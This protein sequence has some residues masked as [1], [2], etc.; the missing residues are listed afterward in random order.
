MTDLVEDNVL[1]EIIIFIGAIVGI[2][3]VIALLYKFL[4]PMTQK[5]KAIPGKSKSLSHENVIKLAE[6]YYEIGQLTKAITLLEEYIKSNPHDLIVREM[7]GNYYIEKNQL[8]KAEKQF[9]HI[10]SI[11]SGNKKALE[12]LGDCYYYQNKHN[13]AVE[14]YARIL[15]QAP[16][17]H[18]ARYKLADALSKLDQ[19]E[20]AIKELRK[21]IAKDH[22]NLD[23]RKKLAELLTNKGEFKRAVAELEEVIKLETNN[24]DIINKC[25]NL[26]LKIG[27]LAN[28]AITFKKAIDIDDSDVN[29]HIRLAN[30]YIK[31]QNYDKA[32]KIYN[33][34]IEKGHEVTPDMQYELANI[35]FGSENYEKA[36]S[37]CKQLIK[38]NQMVEKASFL[39]AASCRKLD[40]FEDA[41]NAFKDLI[42]ETSSSEREAKYKNEIAEVLCDWGNQN[43]AKA[44]YTAA[45]DK[46][47]EAVHYNPK[48]PKYY[49][50]LGKTNQ[51]TKNYDS[52]ISHFNKTLEFS[53]ADIE[54]L[55]NI[56]QAYEEMEDNNTAIQLYYE[57]VKRYPDHYQARHS[58]GI[59]LG[60]AGFHEQARTELAKAIE[61]EPE[62]PDAYF[63][64]GLVYELLN[65]F[66]KAKEQ[67][68]KA[69]DLDPNHV[70]ARNNLEILMER[71]QNIN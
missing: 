41:F 59:A 6:E 48:N 2:G 15:N 9:S 36:I 10:L 5:N 32:S 67:Y 23:A 57:A 27:D 54:T 33:D 45:L 44:D 20:Q 8:Q 31:L 22:Y 47:V 21:I 69:L 26:Y 71:H 18:E 19:V 13:K 64:Y 43:F 58:L 1:N 63:N 53:N 25:A 16:D 28:A 12:K 70:E 38:A 65:D 40:R 49:F 51:A 60:A 24:T 50:Y 35:Y 30:I 14:I 11:D 4:L 52:A 3:I 7:L 39:I 42:Q 55:L 46:F 29:A 56:A 17:Y 62:N 66:E 61:I 34:L 68:K 37:I